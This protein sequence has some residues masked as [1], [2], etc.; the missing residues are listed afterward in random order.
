M[1]IGVSVAVGAEGPGSGRAV[2]RRRVVVGVKGFM[3]T[4]WPGT[5]RAAGSRWE[6][7][8]VK[9]VAGLGWVER[10][11]AVRRRRVMVR[12]MGCMGTGRPERCRR[13]GMCGLAARVS[14][15]VP[16]VLHPVM[17]RRMHLRNDTCPNLVRISAVHTT[18]PSSQVNVQLHG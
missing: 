3:R 11:R 15:V 16:D 10:G 6:L 7:S 13:A 1:K 14:H 8:G 4:G 9:G 5:C 12:A 17:T 18:L 2:G